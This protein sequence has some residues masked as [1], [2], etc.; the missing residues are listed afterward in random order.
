[1]KKIANILLIIFACTSLVAC[2]GQM[3]KQGGGT[4]LGGVAGG[5][6]G[7]QF[8]KGEGKI[9]AT[10]AGALLGG[11]MGNQI[12]Q[13]MDRQDQ[14]LA[15][16]ASSRA[17]E[18]ARTGQSTS[19]KNPD[20]GNRGTI[21]PTRTYQNH[22]QYCREYQHNIVVGG[23]TQKAFGRACRQPDGQWKVVN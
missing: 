15:H 11:F 19:W 14:M 22:G 3:N 20:S 2:N 12:G 18:N 16:R 21:T 10:A 8:G 17:L 13:T 7:S 9:L 6:L 4:I 5:L 23:K 1:M